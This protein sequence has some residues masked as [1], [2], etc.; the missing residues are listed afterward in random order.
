MGNVPAEHLWYKF[1]IW[2]RSGFHFHNLFVQSFVDIGIIGAAML[3]FVLL[4]PFTKSLSTCLSQSGSFNRLMCAVLLVY[5]VRSYTEVDIIGTYS[6]GPFVFYSIA[7][8]QFASKNLG[9]I[10]NYSLSTGN[11]T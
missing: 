8:R 1:G 5:V 10:S 3:A 9:V 2:H 4:V 7:L 11:Q 6:I